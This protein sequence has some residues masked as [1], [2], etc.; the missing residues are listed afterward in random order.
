MLDAPAEQ[1]TGECVC[2]TRVCVRACGC[3]RD[4]GTIAPRFIDNII[5]II[6]TCV[7]KTLR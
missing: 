5:I 2:V 1:N 6:I 7:Y 3:V 4:R